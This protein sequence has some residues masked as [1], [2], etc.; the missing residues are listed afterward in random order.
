[1]RLLFKRAQK[2]AAISKNA[3]RK[4]MVK[5]LFAAFFVAGSLFITKPTASKA[6]EKPAIQRTVSDEVKGEVNNRHVEKTSLTTRNE[7]NTNHTQERQRKSASERY[8]DNI[9]I[10]VMIAVLVL[11]AFITIP[12]FIA[13]DFLSEK[14]YTA[15]IKAKLYRLFFPIMRRKKRKKLIYRL[16][17]DY[18]SRNPL[19][20]EAAGVILK[21]LAKAHPLK[22]V[23]KTFNPKERKEIVKEI[24]EELSLSYS[25]D[26]LR[27]LWIIQEL[28]IFEVIP[29][30]I[31]THEKYTNLLRKHKDV[32]YNFS[33]FIK[34]IEDTL[35]VLVKKAK[36]KNP[37]SADIADSTSLF[38]LLGKLCQ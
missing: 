18:L 23:F 19:R 36:P 24:E 31:K 26:Y 2:H 16:T 30:L 12:F 20:Y 38:L 6:M 3:K 5:K 10:N 4:R 9:F 25:K 29:A 15:A 32:D 34:A 1:M 28:E 22:E 8:N 14:G 35:S 13:M 7:E 37:F 17:L 33:S 27:A 11:G 21:E